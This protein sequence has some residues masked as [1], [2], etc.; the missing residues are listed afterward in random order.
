MNT[1]GDLSVYL[2]NGAHSH[3]RFHHQR[4]LPL[5]FGA[6]RSADPAWMVHK[7]PAPRASRSARNLRGYLWASTW[8]TLA[9]W[10]RI[11]AATLCRARNSAARVRP[12]RRQRQRRF[13]WPTFRLSGVS[14]WPLPQIPGMVMGSGTRSRE[15]HTTSVLV[16]P[17]RAPATI[18]KSI[19]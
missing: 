6:R 12:Q 16:A 7:E 4:Y 1:D 3:P 15:K 11:Y 18:F 2:V 17:K 14:K 10:T 19:T 13:A 5:R 9:S 8:I